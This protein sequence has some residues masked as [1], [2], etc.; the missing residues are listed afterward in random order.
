MVGILLE[1]TLGF[2]NSKI[3]LL[4]GQTW[5]LFGQIIGY[6]TPVTLWQTR[7]K[8]ASFCFFFFLNWCFYTEGTTENN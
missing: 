2:G 3:I 5:G 8:I 1:A 6:D 4:A 7:P